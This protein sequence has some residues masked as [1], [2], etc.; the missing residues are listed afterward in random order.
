MSHYPVLDV[1][2]STDGRFLYV[3]AQNGAIHKRE[4]V[5][6]LQAGTLNVEIPV[7]ALRLNVH[8]DDGRV[9]VTLKLGGSYEVRLFD[10]Q[11]TGLSRIGPFATVGAGAVVTRNV[12]PNAIV[13]G[14]PARI[15]GDCR[16]RR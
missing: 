1:A 14:N 12:P 13:I 10:S 16:N 7:E 4:A 9:A 2:W 8:P 3:G 11:G 5:S 6:G 15:V